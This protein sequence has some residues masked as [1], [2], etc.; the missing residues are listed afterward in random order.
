M[1]EVAMRKAAPR[2]AEEVLFVLEFIIVI[3]D[4]PQSRKVS[5]PQ[6]GYFN[7]VIPKKIN[8]NLLQ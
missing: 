3:K 5:K 4:F 1:A 8:L 7:L 2:M 6:S